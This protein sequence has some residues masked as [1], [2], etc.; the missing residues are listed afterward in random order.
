MRRKGQGVTHVSRDQVDTL[1]AA[2]AEHDHL[3]R[4]VDEIEQ[5]HRVVFHANPRAD[6]SLVRRSAEQILVAEILNR[7][8]GQADGIYFALR[9]LED[10]GQSWDAAVRTLAATIHSYYTTPLGVVMRQDLFG[11]AAIFF[12]PDARDWMMEMQSARDTAKKGRS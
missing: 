10:A 3:R 6:W 1:M 8:D 12:T 11:A 7:H 5:K 9:K 4:V 2:L